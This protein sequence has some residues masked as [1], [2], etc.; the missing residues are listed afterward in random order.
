MGE[1]SCPPDLFVEAFVRIV[2]PKLGPLPDCDRTR[3][4]P[5][6]SEVLSRQ[7][8]SPRAETDLLDFFQSLSHTA[9]YDQQRKRE[10]FPNG[11]GLLI[12]PILSP[13]IS[14]ALIRT[15][16]SG[17]AAT[18]SLDEPSPE[19]SSAPM[20]LGDL[21]TAE[22]DAADDYGALYMESIEADPNAPLEAVGYDEEL[23]V[24][25]FDSPLGEFYV[26]EAT[27]NEAIDYDP[28]G[29]TPSSFRA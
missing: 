21:S 15:S 24:E 17:A 22:S 28:L 25:V 2:T 12:A 8:H 13:I 5:L 14:L 23:G 16:T 27:A 4:M 3:R 20:P 11:R 10:M 29:L 18:E 7:R 1:L 6:I 26:D 19:S 9:P